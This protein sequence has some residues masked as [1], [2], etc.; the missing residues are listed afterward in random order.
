MTFV[1]LQSGGTSPVLREERKRV[2]RA[3]ASSGASSFRIRGEMPSGPLAFD[4]SRPS[5]SFWTPTWVMFIGS[6]MGF[7]EG[8]WAVR[9]VLVSN[10]ES[11]KVVFVLNAE[12]N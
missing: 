4:G 7:E 5:K 12:K 10:S 9:P 1:V 3:G 6:M 2:V 11:K 8:G